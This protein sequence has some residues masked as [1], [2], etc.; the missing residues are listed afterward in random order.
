MAVVP[1]PAPRHAA[2][3]QQVD[4]DAFPQTRLRFRTRRRCCAARDLRQRVWEEI[5]STSAPLVPN[6]TKLRSYGKISIK[7]R[8]NLDYV[9]NIRLH[10]WQL[11]VVGTTAAWTRVA[12][13]QKRRPIGRRITLPNAHTQGRAQN[14]SQS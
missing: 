8:L 1:S 4:C 12:Q 7:Y 5:T 6:A 11:R 10:V 2:T 3:F 14:S 13:A 9:L